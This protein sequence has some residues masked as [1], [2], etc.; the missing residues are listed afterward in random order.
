[1]AKEHIRLGRQ[2]YVGLSPS[3]FQ[4]S[5]PIHKPDEQQ[6]KNKKR[7]SSIIIR[8]G[9]SELNQL[10]DQ[11]IKREFHF[12]HTATVAMIL[13]LQN[14]L[15]EYSMNSISGNPSTRKK[16][17]RFHTASSHEINQTERRQYCE[18]YY[19]KLWEFVR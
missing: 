10:S 6:K 3:L 13:K 16:S 18:Y 2:S 7:N 11:I 4:K 19:C 8:A 14:Y 9:D 1:M 15:E 5:I 12:P 17:K